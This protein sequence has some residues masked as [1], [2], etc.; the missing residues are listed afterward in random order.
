[1]SRRP[2]PKRARTDPSA[3]RAWGTSDRNGMIYNLKDLRYQLQWRGTQLFSNGQLVGPD[4]YD[5]PNRQLG[6]IILPPDPVGV[7]NAR[8]EQYTIDEI[9]PRLTQD[10]Q[11]RYLQRSECSRSL[12]SSFY[13]TNGRTP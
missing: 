6:T 3:P 9:W 2:H 1:M 7:K 11:P 10:G 8:P 4:E 5:V 12:Q 13:Y